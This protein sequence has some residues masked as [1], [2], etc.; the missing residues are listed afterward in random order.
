MFSRSAWSIKHTRAYRKCGLFCVPLSPPMREV[1][2]SWAPP[3][4]NTLIVYS[5]HSH[6]LVKG[7]IMDRC[8]LLT[9]TPECCLDAP[10]DHEGAWCRPFPFVSTNILLIK[11]KL[12]LESRAV[13]VGIAMSPRKLDGKYRC[14]PHP[15]SRK[16]MRHFCS[17][18]VERV[19]R[20]APKRRHRLTTVTLLSI[21][22]CVQKLNFCGTLSFRTKMAKMASSTHMVYI[23]TWTGRYVFKWD[24]PLDEGLDFVQA[25][26]PSCAS[27]WRDAPLVREFWMWGRRCKQWVPIDFRA[28]KC[29]D[30]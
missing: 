23:R 18:E 8:V 25:R 10:G 1:G 27:W 6:E 9:S 15:R 4:M 11:R 16:C 28:A 20:T 12:K 3:L 2:I 17:G 5:V 14:R 24:R 29:V 26:V 22:W 7:L 30:M 13:S 21:L 19:N